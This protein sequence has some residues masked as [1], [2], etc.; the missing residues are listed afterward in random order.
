M[1]SIILFAVGM[2][3]FPVL[4]NSQVL[5]GYHDPIFTDLGVTAGPIDDTGSSAGVNFES[6][7]TPSG[8][9]SLLYDVV[10]VRPGAGSISESTAG[11]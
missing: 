5:V 7:I 6:Q 2:T 4:A 8:T 3:E 9:F 11:V 10:I 1:K